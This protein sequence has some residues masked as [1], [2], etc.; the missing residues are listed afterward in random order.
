M[1]AQSA[2]CARSHPSQDEI[3]RAAGYLS[4][5]NQLLAQ[6]FSYS[7]IAHSMALTAYATAIV[8]Q[9]ESF[10]AFIVAVFG[11]YFAHVQF[12]ITHTLSK[13]IDALRERYLEHDAVYL[14]YK[15]ASGGSRRRGIQT[16]EV[17]TMIAAMWTVLIAYTV[18][19]IAVRIIQELSA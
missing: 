16:V 3:A 5:A 10:I 2:H 8:G 15:R 13:K 18:W 1:D 14:V 4:E 6:R 11:L 19:P 9:R 7:L 12:A 17:P